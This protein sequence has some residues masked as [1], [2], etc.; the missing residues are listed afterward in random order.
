MCFSFSA[1][2]FLPDTARMI[3]TKLHR[4]YALFCPALLSGRFLTEGNI[5][6]TPSAV[7]TIAPP[8]ADNDNDNDNGIGRHNLGDSN[9][10]A[11]ALGE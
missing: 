6:Q 1:C 9:Q 10:D 7:T 11:F 8:P 2:A 5:M 4:V 3:K